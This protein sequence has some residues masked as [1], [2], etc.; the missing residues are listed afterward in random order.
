VFVAVY[1]TASARAALARV[2]SRLQAAP[3]ASAVRW[4]PPASWHVTLRFLG[5]VADLGPIA[6]ALDRLAGWGPVAAQLGPASGWLPGG[7]VLQVPVAGLDTLAAAVRE[8]LGRPP[9]LGGPPL[10][11]EG[12]SPVDDPVPFVG[13]LTLGRARRQP[14]ERAGPGTARGG[15]PKEVGGPPWWSVPVA[16]DLAVRE[17]VLVVSTLGSG[18]PRHD[19]VH[20]VALAGPP[21]TTV[22]A[23]TDV[24]A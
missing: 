16:A 2:L 6:E 4:V 13:H 11:E 10:P 12:R 17:V 8:V 5:T 3:E 22:L 23:R 19:I 9:V 18:P 15:G 7:R 24:R 21:G 20:R 1:P 14:V